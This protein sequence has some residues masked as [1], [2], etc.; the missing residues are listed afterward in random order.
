MAGKTKN[1]KKGT[2]PRNSLNKKSP[3]GNV[4]DAEVFDHE[5][6]YPSSRVIKRAPNGDVIV[7]PLNVSGNSSNKHSDTSTSQKSHESAH[8]LAFTLDSHWESLS[9]QKKMEILKIEKDEVFE[10]LKKHQMDHNCNCAVCGRRHL[11]M[12]QEMERIYTSLFEMERLKDPEMNH[13]K[14]HLSIIKELQV[15]K[16][17]QGFESDL[18]ESDTLSS[19]IGDSDILRESVDFV[20]DGNEEFI[21]NIEKFKDIDTI[22]DEVMH[23]KQKRLSKLNSHQDIAST[24]FTDCVQAD[25]SSRGIVDYNGQHNRNIINDSSYQEPEPSDLSPSTIIE[26]TEVVL[27]GHSRDEYMN[28]TK[29]FISSSPKI[30]EEYVNKMLLYPKIKAITDDLMQDKGHGFLKAIEKFVIK[31][32]YES[33][34]VEYQN[35]TIDVPGQ[36]SNLNDPK[37]FTTMLHNGKPLTS[38]EYVDLQRNIAERMTNAYDLE[39]REFRQVSQLEKELFTRFMFGDDKKQFSEFIIESFKKEFK[40]DLDDIPLYGKTLEEAAA[41]TLAADQEISRKTVNSLHAATD[42]M[43][44][45]YDEVSSDYDLYDEEFEEVDD[46]EE[47]DEDGDGQADFIS[48]DDDPLAYE[49]DSTRESVQRKLKY[50]FHDQ[51][52][53]S[54]EMNESY[55]DEVSRHAHLD[56]EVEEDV[57]DA[58]Y[59]SGIDEVSRMDEGRK[60]IQIAITKLLQGRIMKLYYEKQAENNRLKLL[61]ELEDEQAKKKEKQQKKQKKREKEKEKKRLQQQAKEDERRKRE[62]EREKERIENERREQERREAQRKKVEEAKRKKDEEKRRKLEE[63]RERELQMEKQRKLKEE[64]KRK[65]EEERRKREE[66]KRQKEEKSKVEREKKDQEMKK[67]SVLHSAQNTPELRNGQSTIAKGIPKQADNSTNLPTQ[68][69]ISPSRSK[70]PAVSSDSAPYGTSHQN[71]TDSFE[72]RCIND[73]LSEMISAASGLPISRGSSAFGGLLNRDGD[74]SL[75]RSFGAGE[76]SSLGVSSVPISNSAA[77][78]DNTYNVGNS[79]GLKGDLQGYGNNANLSTLNQSPSSL[80]NWTHVSNPQ[81]RLSSKVDAYN[82][83]PQLGNYISDIGT[84]SKSVGQSNNT[85]FSEELNNL[86]SMLSTSRIADSSQSIAN[87]YEHIPIWNENFPGTT[88]SNLMGS[89]PFYPVRSTVNQAPNSSI[90]HTTPVNRKSSLWGDV[91]VPPSS[92]HGTHTINGFSRERNGFPVMNDLESSSSSIQPTTI[93]TSSTANIWNSASSAYGLSASMVNSD[94]INGTSPIVARS[95]SVNSGTLLQSGAH[96][97]NDDLSTQMLPSTSMNDISPLKASGDD[98]VKIKTIYRYLV[99]RDP[100]TLYVPLDV[101]YNSMLSQSMDYRAFLD[102][103]VLMRSR[104]EC[105]ILADPSGNITH[106]RIAEQNVEGPGIAP[107]TNQSSLLSKFLASNSK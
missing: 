66:E 67:E 68:T 100:T 107:V 24:E 77:Y 34:Q 2:R 1:K 6:E 10:V 65:K 7:E 46:D 98:E 15:S 86:T 72:P 13:I 30:A 44:Q 74:Q 63:Q 5:S 88:S 38:E 81:L 19:H 105:E 59:D 16:Q 89:S 90:E 95:E 62:E 76:F 37:E 25:A 32:Q 64:A 23:F 60:L 73:D 20:M 55:D 50:E 22:K 102:R 49:E 52:Q 40:D 39:R 75:G 70:I 31:N 82:T 41:A 26:S 79:Q 18:L 78:V 94:G 9:P 45:C 53:D 29:R 85:N 58:D 35:H 51:L 80:T 104:N 56:G 84:S 54:S 14:F 36:F 71:N 4:A 83:R 93:S 11:T 96:S 97:V 101:L 33:M 103:L 48:D 12:E 8:S 61:Q 21:N 43:N 91:G 92:S 47:G 42:S 27:D 106:V 3:G 17:H 99:A 28:F 69:H 87:S 57:E